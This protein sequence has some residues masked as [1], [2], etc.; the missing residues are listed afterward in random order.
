[1][2][3]LFHQ[4][5]LEFFFL[6]RGTEL[7][8]LDIPFPI[9][10]GTQIISTNNTHTQITKA[11]SSP[12]EPTYTI[13]TKTVH[14]NIEFCPSHP[15]TSRLGIFFNPLPNQNYIIANACIVLYFGACKAVLQ[16]SLIC[17]I[18]VQSLSCALHIHMAFFPS[19]SNQKG[20][21]YKEKYTY[22]RNKVQMGFLHLVLP[23]NWTGIGV[24]HSSFCKL[25]FPEA[26]P[27]QSGRMMVFSA[28]YLDVF[29]VKNDTEIAWIEM[30]Q[31]QLG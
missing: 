7:S 8:Q 14:L 3:K 18:S 12:L 15:L 1:M 28:S 9:C 19:Y 30:R 22:E 26:F 2:E 20:Q 6:H 16:T 21:N 5:K 24:P 25:W 27:I 17:R 23:C 11:I 31:V 29:Q 10:F 4:Y 13:W